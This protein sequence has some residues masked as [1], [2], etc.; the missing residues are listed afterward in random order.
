MPKYHFSI[1]RESSRASEISQDFEFLAK[2][3][4]L[5]ANQSFL[6]MASPIIH[7]VIMENNSTVFD[8]KDYSQEAVVGLLDIIYTGRLT[9]TEDQVKDEIVKMAQDLEINIQLHQALPEGENVKVKIEAP[10]APEE[11]SENDNDPGLIKMEDG[12]FGCGICFKSFGSKSI[13][14]KHY[15]EVHMTDKNQKNFK[16][17]APNCNKTFAV[18]RHMK[19]HMQRVHGISAKMLKSTK[20]VKV[21][22]VPKKGYKQEPAEQ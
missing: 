2:D 19:L 15:Q 11:P 18:E 7:K 12:R 6:Q 1:V 17:R 5:R 22:K 3:G 10:K 20:S 14:T 21:P 13:G 16:C 4:K 8:L 9:V